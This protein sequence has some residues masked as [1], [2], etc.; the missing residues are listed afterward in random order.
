MCKALGGAEDAEMMLAITALRLRGA[1]FYTM[2][3]LILFMGEK[4][5]LAESRLQC[6]SG[7]Y[8]E[9]SPA[10][11]DKQLNTAKSPFIT[12]GGL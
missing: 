10:G 9:I 5:S 12:L 11:S 3:V 4:N 8:C 2:R 7:G 6:Q 1:A